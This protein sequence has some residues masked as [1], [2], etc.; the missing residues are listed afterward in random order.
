MNIPTQAKT[1]LEWAT[2][3]GSGKGKAIYSPEEIDFIAA[4]I[5]PHQA[6]YVIPVEALRKC[7]TIRLY[8]VKKSHRTGA[9]Y[10][11]Y[12]EAWQLLKEAEMPT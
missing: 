4:Y 8:P 3:P 10:E 9:F 5:A 12:R 1:R 11:A 7:K 2:R 6:W